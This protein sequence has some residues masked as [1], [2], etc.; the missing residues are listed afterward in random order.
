[1]DCNSFNI[2]L[3]D[4]VD[5]IKLSGC[6]SHVN[7]NRMSRMDLQERFSRIIHADLNLNFLTLKSHG[8]TSVIQ[9]YQSTCVQY[10]K[11]CHLQLVQL[12]QQKFLVGKHHK[13]EHYRPY[14][15]LLSI[16]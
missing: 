15:D 2:R 1:M 10:Q 3:K 7:V 4:P 9:L 16:I 5:M 8:S 13:K 14:F 11:Q 6:Q 12:C